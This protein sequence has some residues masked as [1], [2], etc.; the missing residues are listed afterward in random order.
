MSVQNDGEHSDGEGAAPSLDPLTV[1]DPLLKRYVEDHGVS[2]FEAALELS[3]HARGEA[4]EAYERGDISE[5]RVR[6]EELGAQCSQLPQEIQR[7]EARLPLR[8]ALRDLDAYVKEHGEEVW[9]RVEEPESAHAGSNRDRLARFVDS[10]RVFEVYPLSEPPEVDEA[11]PPAPG[12]WLGPYRARDWMAARVSELDPLYKLPPQLYFYEAMVALYEATLEQFKEEYALAHL[13]L[14]AV[15]EAIDYALKVGQL[16]GDQGVSEPHDD[17]EIAAIEHKARRVQRLISDRHYVA[18][19]AARLLR[20]SPQLTLKDVHGALLEEVTE[21]DPEGRLAYPS[22]DSLSDS[23]R[24][25]YN[26]RVKEM[27]EKGRKA[28]DPN[29]DS[30][31]NGGC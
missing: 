22:Y 30:D 7:L 31:G 1:L 4:A 28:I 20:E 19:E 23:L 13:Q 25:K 5:L 26:T 14:E 24:R 12:S 9:I 21:V 10:D 15:V 18:L 29:W 6:R 2:R 11:G 17:K 27:R 8:R 16:P 3:R